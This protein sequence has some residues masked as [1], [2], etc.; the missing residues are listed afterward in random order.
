MK[1][2]LDQY[3]AAVIGVISGISCLAFLYVFMSAH[4][5]ML[6]YL[7]LNYMGIYLGVFHG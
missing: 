1:E 7:V 5:G 6:A 2:I 4:N 3:G